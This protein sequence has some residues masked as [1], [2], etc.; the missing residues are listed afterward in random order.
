[1]AL[2]WATAAPAQTIPLADQPGTPAAVPVGGLAGVGI[3]QTKL[4]H[5]V[6]LDLPFVDEQGRN[7]TI[8]RYFGKRPVVLAL[9]YF[10]CPMLCSLVQN[11]LAD[12]LAIVTPKAGRDFDVV[13]ASINPAETPAQAADAKAR[14]V[15]RYRHPGTDDG[16]HFLTGRESSVKALAD[17]VG[18]RYKYDPTIAQFAHPAVIIVLTPEARV[19]R[20]LFGL[21]YGAT[22]LRLALDEAA[23]GRIGNVVDQT[24]LYC[25]HY[26]PLTG[27]YSL[28]VMSLIRLGGLLTVLGIMVSVVLA[29]RRQRRRAHAVAHTAGVH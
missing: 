3:D 4:N 27:R 1:M 28:A 22:D 10:D 18:F 13:V 15:T 20:Y 8:G 12:T 17:A 16:L 25:Y 23:G 24:L 29:V 21:D 7:I 26:D 14:M 6:P 2:T 11:A 5:Q 19:S 9:V